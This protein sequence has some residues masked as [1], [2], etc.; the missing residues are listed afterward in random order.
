MYIKIYKY[1]WYYQLVLVPQPIQ[2]GYSYGSSRVSTTEQSA[3]ATY[4]FLTLF[5]EEFPEYA[6]KYFHISGESYGKCAQTNEDLA[7]DN[8]CLLITR[9]LVIAGHYLPALGREIVKHQQSSNPPNFKLDSV[10]IGNGW[11]D[12]LIQ[13]EK[14]IDFGCDEGTIDRA[15][16]M[17]QIVYWKGCCRITRVWGRYLWLHES[18]SSAMHK[19][20]RVLLQAPN[21]I[22]MYACQPSLREAGIRMHGKRSQWVSMQ[23]NMTIQKQSDIFFA[24]G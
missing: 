2:V 20:D 18:L 15:A 12:P 22:G 1:Y 8:V 5:F 17:L 9:Y 6:R 3:K 19:A 16:V 11:T 10:L 14:Y 13:N 7:T 23:N 4:A 24:Y 21:H